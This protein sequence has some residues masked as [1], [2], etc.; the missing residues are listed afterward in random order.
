MAARL[1]AK[2]SLAGLE[3]LR[4]SGE[5]VLEAHER[6][7]AALRR[8]GAAAAAVAELLA[9][10][11]VSWPDPGDPEAGGSISWYAEAATEPAPLAALPAEQRAAAAARLHELL[12]PVPALLAEPDIARLLRPALVLAAADGILVAGERIVLIGWGLA[13]TAVVSSGSD[14]FPASPLALYVPALAPTPAAAVPQAPAV[15]EAMASAPPIA[16]AQP[17]RPAPPMP[18][19]VSPAGGTPRSGFAWAGTAGVWDWALVPAALVVA[20]IFLALGVWLG[21]RVL[22]DRLLQRPPSVAPYNEAE[23]EAEIGRQELQ[24]E[25]LQ[26]EIERR[27]QALQSGNVCAPDPAQQPALGPDRNAPVPPASLPPPAAGAPPFQGSLA[28]LLTQGVVL[29]IASGEQGTATGSGFFV[30][31]DTIVTNRHVI[32]H[33]APGKIWVTSAKLGHVTPVEVAASTPEQQGEGPDFAILRLPAP[34]QVQPLAFSTTAA[35]LDPVF[36]AGYPGVA[37]RNDAAF[38]RLLHGD[39]TAVPSVILTDGRINAIQTSREGVLIMPHSAAIAPGN[40]GGPLTD[41]CGRVLGINTFVVPDRETTSHVNYALKAEP[42]IAFLKEN[43]VNPTVVEGA[44]NPS[45]APATPSPPVP[46]APSPQAA[47]SPAPSAPPPAPDPAR[48]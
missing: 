37:T 13:P 28:A 10:P 46:A 4:V 11:L 39:A 33:G 45:A 19:A 22:A 29:V 16:A 26:K 44:C 42:I 14:P 24:N 2:T 48:P 15:E 20:A 38:D 1:L 47:P 8:R 6:L 25:G 34:A 41:A 5:P 17:P 40:S 21:G 18:A 36:A 7:Q 35:Q 27:R 12:R 23:L 31:P 3:P 9:E 30:T 32:A 43:Q